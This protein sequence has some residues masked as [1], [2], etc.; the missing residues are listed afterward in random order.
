M[1]DGEEEEKEGKVGEAMVVLKK[2]N[3]ISPIDVYK[4]IYLYLSI[5][6]LFV[7]LMYMFSR[8]MYIKKAFQLSTPEEM[9][10][11]VKIKKK[12]EY[13]IY[14]TFGSLKNLLSTK[15]ESVRFSQ[16]ISIQCLLVLFRGFTLRRK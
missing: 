3:M 4:F 13:L 15:N 6:S 8:P 12:Q 16:P 9:Q 11:K 1:E 10:K 14:K 5:I 7:H 2:N